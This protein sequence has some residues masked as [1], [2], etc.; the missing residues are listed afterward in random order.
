MDK[1]DNPVKDKNI[2]L[3]ISILKEI[4]LNDLA[5]EQLLIHIGL[6]RGLEDIKP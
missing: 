5:I 2:D 4:E 1:F 6:K 3:L